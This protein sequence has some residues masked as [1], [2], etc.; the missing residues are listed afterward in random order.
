MP[1]TMLTVRDPEGGAVIGELPVADPATAEAALAAAERAFRDGPMPAHRRA[2]VLARAATLVAERAESFAELIATEGVKTI[3]E[4]RR[5]AARCAETLRLGAEEAKRLDGGA[6][7]LDQVP[8]GEGRIGFYERRA[9]GPVIGITPFNDPLNLV[10]HKVAPAIAS[11]CPVI[12]K[13]HPKTPFSALRLRDLLREAGLPEPQFEVL[14][15]GAAVAAR[16]TADPR[17]RLVSFTGGREGGRAVAAAA[18]GK[19]LTLELGGVG[20]VAVAADADLEHAAAAIHAG[21]F[22]AAGQNCVHAQRIIADD[23]VHDALA[24]RLVGRAAAMRLGRKRDETTDMGPCVDEASA[25]RLAAACRRA[26]A[27]GATLACGGHHAGT[28][29]A[30]TWLVDVADGNPVQRE[31]L[32]GPVST[33]ERAPGFD[34][35]LRRVGAAGDAIHMALFSASLSNALSMW[36][37]APAAAVI[38]NDSTD[39]RIDAMP[40]GGIGTAGLGREGVRDAIEAMTEKRMMILA[41]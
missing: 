11:G 22:W 38:V 23:A 41:A 20:V 15:G 40:F 18:A 4:A 19:R 12:V 24:E 14:V 3:R 29:F 39:F 28:R 6:V 27:A 36:R 33:L 26:V 8:A 32:F 25:E 13:P 10:A 17:P 2:A 1:P 16:L 5:E 9:A 30:P 7:P 31:E 37:A 21:A 35:I 34:D